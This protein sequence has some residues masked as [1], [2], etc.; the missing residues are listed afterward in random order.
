[1]DKV[2]RIICENQGKIFKT[3]CLMKLNMDEFVPA[4]MKSLFCEKSMDVIW[5]VF[6]FAD[7]EECLD[8]IVPEIRPSVMNSIKY[9]P[10]I[11]DWV[12]FAYRQL[13]F[14]LGVS[15]KEIYDKVSFRDMLVYHPGLHTVDE[16]MAVDIII[17]NKFQH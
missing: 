12:G 17:E 1:M 10:A 6:Q 15:S 13:Y 14:S 4:Y 11:M 8:F 2:Q 5:S 3:A 9:Q 16:D 7:A